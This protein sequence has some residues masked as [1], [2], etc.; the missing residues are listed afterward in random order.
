[1]KRKVLTILSIISTL[2]VVIWMISDFFGG[3]IIYLFMYAWIIIPMVLMYAITA[4][5]T[6]IK[7]IKNGI[8]SNRLLFYTHSLGL[9]MIIGFNLYQSEIFKSRILLNATLVDDLN[10]INL[11]LREN[12]Q[13][14]MTSEG[15]FGYTDRISGKYKTHKDTI[16]FLKRPYSNDFISNKVIIDRQDSAIY[17]KKDS[18]G[19]FS[20][21]KTFVNYFRIDKIDL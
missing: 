21:E 12:G 18:M 2:S 1:M 8:K 7:I 5:I 4:F 16:I 10:C 6:L 14:E 19:K 9:L 15:M 20:R 11:I 17:F 13:F 3:M